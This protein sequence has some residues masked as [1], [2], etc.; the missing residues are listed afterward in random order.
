MRN[1]SYDKLEMQAYL[2]RND[3]STELKRLYFSWRIRM[4]NFSENFRGGNGP[5]NCRL[6]CE[7][8]DSQ[9][10]SFNCSFIKRRINIE[11]N[12]S[13]IFNQ[14]YPDLPKLVRT[15]HKITQIRQEILGK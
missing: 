6:C 9:E 1:L 10:E 7:H 3:L 14:Y 11:V 12:Y 4:T 2:T 13:S 5:Q 15:L 8:I